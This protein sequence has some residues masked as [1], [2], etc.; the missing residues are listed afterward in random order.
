MIRDAA[1]EGAKLDAYLELRGVSRKQI[2]AQL[3][4]DE[5]TISKIVHGKQIPDYLTL[6]RVGEEVRGLSKR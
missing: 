3:D 6:I 4:T 2:A 1:R 5:G